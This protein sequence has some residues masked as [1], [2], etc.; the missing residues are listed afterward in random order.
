MSADI[1]DSQR[2]FDLLRFEYHQHRQGLSQ[3]YK[4]PQF[5]VLSYGTKSAT[6]QLDVEAAHPFLLLNWYQHFEKLRQLRLADPAM[7]GAQRLLTDEI[8]A[9][10][11]IK[12]AKP[13]T[14]TF[15]YSLEKN[16]GQ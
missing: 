1:S 6:V 3:L 7:P 10:K 5:S 2:E 15:I 14:G 8:N 4:Q 16:Y 12:L 11:T 9:T 13:P